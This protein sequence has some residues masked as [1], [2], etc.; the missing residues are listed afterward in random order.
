MM[1]SGGR[2]E[3]RMAYAAVDLLVT[4]AFLYRMA[5]VLSPFV[6]FLLLLLLV[7]PFAGTRQHLLLVSGSAILTTLWLLKTAGSVWRRSS[8]SSRLHH[9]SGGGHA[10]A[11][12]RAAGS[13]SCSLGLPF[14]VL[15]VLAVFFGIR[16]GTPDG[17][18]DRAMRPG[19]VDGSSRGRRQW[20][21]LGGPALHPRGD[22]VGAAPIA[23]R[24]PGGQVPAGSPESHGELGGGSRLR[25]RNRGAVR[26]PGYLV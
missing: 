9:R 26:D 8:A 15:L 7:S 13:A 24:D 16:A 5:P 18:L 17:G 14:V 11:A 3:W 4:A 22:P 21:V 10:R 25:T 19:A 1:R 12:A 6:L 20:W 23:R 2:V